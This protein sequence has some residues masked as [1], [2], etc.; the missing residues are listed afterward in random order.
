[1][2]ELMYAEQHLLQNSLSNEFMRLY[3]AVSE[4]YRKYGHSSKCIQALK[5]FA[6]Y[7]YQQAIQKKQYKSL[8]SQLINNVHTS[9]M[10]QKCELF[11]DDKISGCL[12]A[13]PA[14]SIISDE[15]LKGNVNILT[16][17]HGAMQIEQS[18]SKFRML[19][20]RLTLGQSSINIKSED[21]KI[22]FHAK[23]NV[24]VFLCISCNQIS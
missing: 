23:T 16:I 3:S 22:S 4:A 19:S 20:E 2:G 10:A 18:A 24:A 21:K 14:T 13:L 12:Y 9:G 8:R 15:L 1:M 6:N 17:D 7:F 11:Y 5:Q